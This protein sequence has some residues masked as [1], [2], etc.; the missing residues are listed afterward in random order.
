M[1]DSLSGLQVGNFQVNSRAISLTETTYLAPIAQVKGHTFVAFAQGN[2]DGI[3]HF[4]TLGN[5]TFGLEDL[6]G[7]GDRDFNDVEFG[8]VFKSVTPLA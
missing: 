1:V 2:Q 5:G 7:G 8:F 6:Y 3:G 4:V